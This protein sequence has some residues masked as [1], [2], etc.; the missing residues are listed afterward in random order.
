MALDFFEEHHNALDKDFCKHVIEKF[1]KDDTK[2]LGCTASGKNSN[3]KSSIDLC[4]F[5][6]PNWEEEDKIFYESLK[7]YTTSY[8]SKYHL[9]CSDTYDTGYQIQR[10]KPGKVGYVW[11]H[12]ST[13]GRDQNNNCVQRIITYLW[14][15]N[16]TVGGSGTTEFYD[17]THV[18]PEEGKLILFP[19]TWTH[20]HMGHPP[21]KG[22][23]YICTGWIWQNYGNIDPILY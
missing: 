11:H 20:R 8:I 6:D 22:L 3:L 5:G 14:Y 9:N 13:P 15:L 17:G 4:F 1:E 19:A 10:T 18:K 2:Q 12:D 21:K 16:T 7:K 23:K